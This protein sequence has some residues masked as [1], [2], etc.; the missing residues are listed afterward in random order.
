MALATL[1]DGPLCAPA[2]GPQ[3]QRGRHQHRFDAHIVNPAREAGRDGAIMPCARHSRDPEPSCSPSG[4]PIRHR[5][6]KMRE[7]AYAGSSCS[8]K[9][10]EDGG[11]QHP[12]WP[13]DGLWR[14]VGR[15]P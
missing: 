8:P 13:I 7:M 3:E 2:L 6:Q 1:R 11:S 10:H 4:D 9:P 5:S 15:T 12:V 14:A